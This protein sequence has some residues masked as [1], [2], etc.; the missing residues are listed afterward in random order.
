MTAL[1]GKVRVTVSDKCP[2]D[3][4]H[5]EPPSMPLDILA[6]TRRG[7]WQAVMNTPPKRPANSEEVLSPVVI[8]PF[9]EAYRKADPTEECEA[10]AHVTVYLPPRVRIGAFC[11][12]CWGRIRPAFAFGQPFTEDVGGFAPPKRG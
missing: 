12:A 10:F 7:G 4:H 9:C 2:C 1:Q 3:H 11:T 5:R 8:G 6:G